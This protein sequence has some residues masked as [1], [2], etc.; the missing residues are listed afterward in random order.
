MKTMN[1]SIECAVIITKE[2]SVKNQ[3]GDDIITKNEAI[4]RTTIMTGNK[5]LIKVKERNNSLI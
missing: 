3:N 1:N 4:V 5:I 2:N